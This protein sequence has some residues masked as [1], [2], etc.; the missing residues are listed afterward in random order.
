MSLNKQIL[1]L[2]L[3]CAVLCVACWLLFAGRH[4]PELLAW[5]YPNLAALPYGQVLSTVLAA[6]GLRPPR[7]DSLQLTGEFTDWAWGGPWCCSGL[8]WRGLRWQRRLLLWSVKPAEADMADALPQWR[9]T[10]A[11]MP[12]QR[13]KSLAFL[14]PPALLALAAV[15][16][17]WRGYAVTTLPASRALRRLRRAGA[18]ESSAEELV[19][20]MRGVLGAG[21]ELR[22]PSAVCA[23]T[24]LA[25]VLPGLLTELAQQLDRER[26]AGCVPSPRQRR[27]RLELI[28][29]CLELVRMLP[30]QA[31][32]RSRQSRDLGTGGAPSVIRR[33]G[34]ERLRGG[35]S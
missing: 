19:Q 12:A 9:E 11:P 8:S 4:E 2:A 29:R 24:S 35:S 32:A 34:F 21:W 33:P 30:P 10:A 7:D 17:C 20:L 18:E 5:H 15:L 31:R 6:R 16:A 22:Y 23:F 1:G 26:F 25:T 13:G 27:S 28:R 14:L 3:C